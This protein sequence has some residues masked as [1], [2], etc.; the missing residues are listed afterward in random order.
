MDIASDGKIFSTNPEPLAELLNGIDKHKIALPNFQRPWIWQPDMV[1]GLIISVAYRYPAGSLLTM[2]V[3]GGSFALRPFEGTGDELTDK[4]N[5]MVLDGQQRLTSLYQALYSR[6]GVRVKG[7]TYYFYLDIPLLMSDEDGCIEVGEPCFD[8]ALFYVSEER[9]GKKIRYEGL[10]PVY[11]LT[12]RQDE[13]KAGAM[14]LWAV[15]DTTDYMSQ[16]KDEYLIT[17]LGED[18]PLSVYKEHNNKWDKLVRPWIERIKTYPFPV[19]ELT[20]NMPLG[21]ICHIFEKVNSTGVPL[22]VFDLCTAIL[23]AQGFELNHEW[24]RLKKE[25]LA[26]LF[27]MQELSGTYF[28]QGLSLLASHERKSANP[29][30]NIAVA[31]RKQDLMTLKKDVVEKWWDILIDGYIEAAKFMREQGIISSRILPYSTIIIPLS[32]IFAYLKWKKGS[33]KAGAAWTKIQQWYWCSVFSQR[34]SSQVE[35]LSARDFEQVINWIDGG[36]EPDVVRTFMFRSDYLQEIRSIRSAIYKGVLCLLVRNGA[37]DFGGG[38]MLTTELF[39]GTAQDHHHIFPWNALKKL[40]INDPRADSIVNKTLIGYAVNRSI[41]GRLPS[42]YVKQLSDNIDKE[43]ADVFDSILASHE[44]SA[45][46]LRNNDWQGFINDRRERLRLLIK[47][48]CGKTVQPFSD[49][50]IVVDEEVDEDEDYEVSTL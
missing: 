15:F 24:A 9:N 6:N 19:V 10:Q 31:C 11:E 36:D 37:K 38:G 28:L 34:Y 40:D 13:L 21:A 8:K 32:S 45:T 25:K 26:P 7:K 16:W 23:W 43:N 5:L 46:M 44:I 4:P 29:N 47:S 17:M 49:A 30:S 50:E 14:P 27:P 33:V 48:A 2:P 20:E 35:Y 22:D 39:F 3:N 41:G 12:T 1:H 18:T 42:Q